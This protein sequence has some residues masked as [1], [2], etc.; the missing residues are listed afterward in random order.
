M[1]S[2]M[3]NESKRGFIGLFI[4]V[5]LLEKD[6]L[7]ITDK[8]FLAEI[9]A[10]EHA[11]ECFASNKHFQK[12]SHLSKSRVSN[13]LSNLKA[14]GYISIKL[15]YKEDSK[16]ISKRVIKLN[17]YKFNGLAEPNSTVSDTA[18]PVSNTGLPRFENSEDS[19]TLLDKH[20]ITTSN[21]TVADSKES[22]SDKNKTSKKQ[23]D[24]DF[25]KLWKLYP[26]KTDKQTAKKKYIKAIKDGTTNKE[27]QDGIVGYLK[28]IKNLGTPLHYVKGGGTW[29]SK[30]AWEDE[31]ETSPEPHVSNQS[32][33]SKPKN[34][35]DSKKKD[36]LL[37][38]ARERDQKFIEEE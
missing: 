24:E 38:E 26:R 12:F 15:F 13:I 20:N 33:P 3:E 17:R 1:K 22:A 28:Q 14:K 21:K 9:N 35:I 29:F 23:L 6:D 2:S 5:E 31:Y 32:K 10:L 4:P 37:R 11:G 8:V 30:H 16:Q 19:I 7:T 34:K 27:I 36:E 25:E 18:T